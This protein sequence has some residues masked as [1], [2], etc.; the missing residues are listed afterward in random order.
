ML[1]RLG[2]A[3]RSYVVR[4]A[5][6]E[7]PQRSRRDST[8]FRPTLLKGCA[9]PDIR[10][11][12][13]EP[14]L[15]DL[16][17]QRVSQERRSLFWLQALCKM[18]EHAAKAFNFMLRRTK[19]SAQADVQRVPR[20][21]PEFEG[22]RRLMRR[23]ARRRPDEGAFLAP[24]PPSRGTSPTQTKAGAHAEKL[25]ALK[26]G[27]IFRGLATLLKPET[28]AAESETIARDVLKRIGSK[29]RRMSGRV[30]CS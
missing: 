20:A 18:D 25:H 12:V 15:V 29:T 24:S 13:V 28:T 3:Y 21:A 10:H 19:Q 14:I 5:E 22:S 17:P 23:G 4:F 16:F 11:H 9:Q 6:A 27:N 2:T 8:G 26:D 30:C 1:K 7:T